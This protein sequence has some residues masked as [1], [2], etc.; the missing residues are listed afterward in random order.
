M[1][2]P[3]EILYKPLL[4]EKVIRGNTDNHKSYAFWVAVSANKREIKKAVEDQFKVKVE[5]VHTIM[6]RSKPKRTRM[7]PGQTPERKK[8]IVTLQPGKRIDILEN[9]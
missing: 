9:L 5:A 4:V 3:T 8:A 6:V 7:I 2:H 1:K